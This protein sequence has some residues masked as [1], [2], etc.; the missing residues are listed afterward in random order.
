MSTV[1]QLPGNRRFTIQ[2]QGQSLEFDVNG[3][4]QVGGNPFGSWTTNRSNQIVVTRVQGAAIAIPVGWKFNARNQLVILVGT[5]P[6]FTLAGAPGLRPQY[7]TVNAVLRIRPNKPDAFVFELRGTW[8]MDNKHNLQFTIDGTTSLI[9]GF[10][11][12]P[13]G[14]FLYT[15]AD[16]DNPLMTSVL[17]FAGGWEAS[18]DG[19]AKAIFRYALEKEG[20][21]ATFNLPQSLAIRT[22]TNQFVYSYDKN[23]R[24]FTIQLQGMLFVDPDFRIT[25]QVARQT[26]SS[27]AELV[28]AT[29]IS[30]AAEISRPNFH[31]DLVLQLKTGAGTGTTLVIGGTFFGTKGKTSI[32][33]G[34]T[35]TQTFGSNSTLVRSVGFDGKIT[36]GPHGEAFWAFTATGTTL[37]LAV[38][39]DVKFG[40][41]SGDARLN[42]IRQNGE[43]VGVTFLLGVSF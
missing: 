15:F 11:A 14:R 39:V 22:S 16:K 3:N 10:V 24:T 27:G 26:S 35:Y 20:E 36:F 19:Q 43:V 38:G 21:T 8:A 30:L 6:V 33:A 23:N 7:E 9:D 18:Q 4:V 5:Q 40:D 25:Y 42:V 31:G 13:Q 37:E 34:F 1:S 12:D 2:F 41:I 17:G 32:Q 29:L 28:K